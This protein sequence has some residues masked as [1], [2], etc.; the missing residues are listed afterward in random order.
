MRKIA[1]KLHLVLIILFLF[2]IIVSS[3]TEAKALTLHS[4]IE[5]YGTWAHI[6]GG[7][8]T[9]V[10]LVIFI[11]VEL[12]LRGLKY[13]TPD[14]KKIENDIETLKELDLPKLYSRGLWAS[15]EGFGLLSALFTVLSGVM[16]FI[17]MNSGFFHLLKEIHEFFTVLIRAYVFIHGA[18]GILYIYTMKQKK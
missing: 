13:F 14:F 9:G 7:M 12:K 2:E 16:W 5:Y 6:I 10:F 1:K 15:F 11:F 8:V 3:I 17:F 4:G 18:M